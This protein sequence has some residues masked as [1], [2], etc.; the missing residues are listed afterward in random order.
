MLAGVVDVFDHGVVEELDL[1]IVARALQHDLGRAEVFAAVHQRHLFA[2]A[3]QEIGLFHGGI[4]AAHHHDLLAA[5]KEAVAGGAAELTP[6][7]ISFCSLGR[8]S[9]RAEAPEAMISV[10]A[11]SHSLIDF[12]AE[13][14]LGKIGFDHACRA[15]TRRRNA[16]PAS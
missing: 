14:A 13:G 5:I 7:P 9:Q 2:E 10:R 15:G 6:W 1:G 16:R 4:A 11:S 3:R 8:F 12:E